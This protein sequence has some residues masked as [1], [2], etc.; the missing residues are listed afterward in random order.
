M[1]CGAHVCECV[2]VAAGEISMVV[3]VM[4]VGMCPGPCGRYSVLG[5]KWGWILDILFLALKE[6]END[7]D[8]ALL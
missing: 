7:I 5:Q 2:Q 4:R 8:I 3:C 1:E 6:T